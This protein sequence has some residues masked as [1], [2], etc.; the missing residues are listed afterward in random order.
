MK[1]YFARYFVESGADAVLLDAVPFFAE[2]SPEDIDLSFLGQLSRFVNFVD[3]I[4]D[5]QLPLL[6]R[7]A[8]QQPLDSQT[9]GNHL[10]P[11]LMAYD[12]RT[13]SHHGRAAWIEWTRCL[14]RLR[15]RE[16]LN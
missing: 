4:H 6:V 12:Q 15:S 11:M 3:A 8:Q 14:S 1:D 9:T 2:I 10:Y 7:G 5:C 13:G 16:A